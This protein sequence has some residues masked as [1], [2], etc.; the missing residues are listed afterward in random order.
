MPNTLR[1]LCACLILTFV[2]L[3]PCW[4]QQVPRPDP[5]LPEHITRPIGGN[6]PLYLAPSDLTAT[7][8]FAVNQKSANQGNHE[9]AYELA[10]AYLEGYGVD[11]DLTLADHWFEVGAVSI[12]EKRQ[13]AEQYLNGRYFPKNLPKVERWFLS[14]GDNF[15]LFDLAKVYRTGALAPPDTERAVAIYLQLLKTTDGHARLAEFEL[16]NLVIDGRYSSGDPRLDLKWAREI[17]QELIGQEQYTVQWANGKEAAPEVKRFILRSAASYDVDLAQARAAEF[18][19]NISPAETYAWLRIAGQN[20]AASRSE[21]NHRSTTMSPA[22]LAEGDAIVAKLQATRAQSGAYYRDDDPLR[23]PDIATLKKQLAHHDDPNQLLRLAFYEES[24]VSKAKPKPDA[25]DLYRRIRNER[26]TLVR[27][28]IGNQYLQGKNGFPQSAT[29]AAGWFS[30]ASE[31]GSSEARTHL[32]AICASGALPPDIFAA[33]N[34]TH[35]D[36]TKSK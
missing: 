22:E 15:S 17:T 16:G 3:S 18:V 1:T 20:R 25:M 29:L 7:E 8:V 24:R 4:A 9:A 5:S 28:G 10:W 30:T 33:S 14:A 31:A 23:S 36:V 32:K 12:Y 35:L 13:V 6:W 19:P 21:A 26:F 11:Q 27:L 2:T 34:C